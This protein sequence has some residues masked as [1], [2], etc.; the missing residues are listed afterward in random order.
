MDNKENLCDYHLDEGSPGICSECGKNFCES[1]RKNYSEKDFFEDVCIRLKNLVLRINDSRDGEKDKFYNLNTYKDENACRKILL[2]DLNLLYE[3]EWLLT[4]EKHEAN[5][6]RV[7]LNLK[8]KK[9]DTFEV[10]IEC[11]KDK[12]QKH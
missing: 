5:D 7:D 12:N 3:K 4:R 11:K 10:Q 6:K 8:Y 1:G 2:S 9:N